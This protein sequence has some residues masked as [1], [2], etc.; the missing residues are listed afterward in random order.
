MPEKTEVR[1]KICQL[2]WRQ[3]FSPKDRYQYLSVL[4]CRKSI[5]QSYV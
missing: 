5:S 2:L 4:F 1:E 3:E